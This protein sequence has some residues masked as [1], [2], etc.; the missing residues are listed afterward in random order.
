[1]TPSATPERVPQE[2]LG[3]RAFLD[4]PRIFLLPRIV[5]THARD[6]VGWG[7]G[8]VLAILRIKTDIT[9]LSVKQGRS[10]ESW[11]SNSKASGMNI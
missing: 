6:G 11:V 5:F 2:A 4:H 10:L 9:R 1:M 3:Y 8:L 7:V